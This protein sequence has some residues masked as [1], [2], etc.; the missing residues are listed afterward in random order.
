MNN[1]NISA[2]CLTLKIAPSEVQLIDKM[3]K[4]HEELSSKISEDNMTPEQKQQF[5]DK[6]GI[7]AEPT[8]PNKADEDAAIATRLEAAHG[9]WSTN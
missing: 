8:A 5:M 7:K 9:E 4:L 2:N 3:N 6:W 1:I